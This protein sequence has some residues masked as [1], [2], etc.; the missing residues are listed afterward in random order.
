MV[1]SVCVDGPYATVLAP[2]RELVRQIERETSKPAMFTGIKCTA[3]VRG[4]DIE[5]QGS[6]LRQG[7]E[8]VSGTPGR[9]LD[10]T[11]ECYGALS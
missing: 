7:C 6:I 8:I 3:I 11:E 4:Q 9:L 1:G 10:C 2:A 5:Q